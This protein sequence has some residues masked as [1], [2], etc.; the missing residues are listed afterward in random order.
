MADNVKGKIKEAGNALGSAAKTAGENTKA[1]A[2]KVAE[3]AADATKAVGNAV[4]KTGES[5]QKRSGT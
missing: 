1:V 3:K 2:V 4:K 5:I